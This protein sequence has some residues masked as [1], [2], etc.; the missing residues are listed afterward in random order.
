MHP[1][2]VTHPVGTIHREGLSVDCWGTDVDVDMITGEYKF[3]TPERLTEH[4]SRRARRFV[5]DE[6]W[7]LIA[8]VTLPLA[9]LAEMAWEPLSSAIGT[10]GWFLLT[11]VFL[12]WG[13]EIAA[14][15]FS[16]GGDSADSGDAKD[17]AVEELKRRYADGEIGDEE[18]ERR[19]DR[20]IAV[21]EA[22]E[23]IHFPRSESDRGYSASPERRSETDATVD[24]T[25]E[26]E[27]E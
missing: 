26:Q 8:V 25:I 6:L 1:E 15:V 7:L 12:F 4:M 24:E 18:F 10:I 11:P 22:D 16:S 2:S 13:D 19:L 23:K 17:D 14:L 27:S 20:L 21:E 3:G 5:A 9:G